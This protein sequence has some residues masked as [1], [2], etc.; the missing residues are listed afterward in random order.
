M[1]MILGYSKIL[2]FAYLASI[3]KNLEKLTAQ[4]QYFRIQILNLWMKSEKLC[5]NLSFIV[6]KVMGNWHEKGWSQFKP[7]KIDWDIPFPLILRI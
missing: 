6:E 1:K 4:D 2:I 5:P 7:N 3:G